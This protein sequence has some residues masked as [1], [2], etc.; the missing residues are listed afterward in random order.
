MNENGVTPETCRFLQI[1][2]RGNAV[3]Y[4]MQFQSVGEVQFFLRDDP[5]RNR[6]VFAEF[7]SET[8]DT[9]FAGP[10]LPQAIEYCIGGYMEQYD[11]FLAFSKQLET[12]NTRFTNGYQ[13]EH[14]FVGQRPNVPAYVAGA[15]KT[16]YRTKRAVEKKCINLFMNVTYASSVTPEQIQYRGIIVLNLISILEQNGYIVNFR[17]FAISHV[18]NEIFLCEVTLKKP[19]DK[20]DSRMCYYPMCG[21]G[22]VRR[23]MARIK[24]SMPFKANWGIG[25]GN[26]L[27]EEQAREY[28]Q[29]KEGDLYIGSPDEM[30]IKGKNIYVD[31]DAV[32]D[33]LGI[34]QHI[35][36]PSYHL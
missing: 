11:Q 6:Q 3:I 26:V 22:F 1:K 21:K 34:R 2:K 4:H 18:R 13:V 15:P 14:S 29:L 19:G 23:I 24:E 9:E 35:V 5:P 16:M 10:K 30:N 36:L 17:L 33:K 32:I 20:L 27:P 28:L 12:V 25:Y 31:A 7:K 8:A